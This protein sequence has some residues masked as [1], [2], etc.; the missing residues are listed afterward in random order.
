MSVIKINGVTVL[1]SDY[2]DNKG[3]VGRTVPTSW[4]WSQLSPLRGGKA[5]HSSSKIDW[6]ILVG[7]ATVSGVYPNLKIS[8]DPRHYL[9]PREAAGIVMLAL[10][11]DTIRPIVR[12]DLKIGRIEPMQVATLFNEWM[13]AT[14][15]REWQAIKLKGE[16]KK[17]LN[18]VAAS[19][20]IT[21]RVL[22]ATVTAKKPV[23]PTTLRNWITAA[24]GRFR[25]D[26]VC[27]ASVIAAVTQALKAWSPKTET[28]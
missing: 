28:R 7:C 19:G 12:P 10:W 6:K 8:V 16:I 14:D 27:P 1:Y 23:P 18:Q 9:T 4:L 21:Y 11:T 17:L 24:G 5:I 13:A 20:Q 25:K 26:S 22:E 3:E 15:G 2:K